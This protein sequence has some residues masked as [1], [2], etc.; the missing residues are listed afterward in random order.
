MN[1]DAVTNQSDFCI[2]N[3]FAVSNIRTTDDPNI[4]HL[5]CFSD[6]NF[7]KNHFF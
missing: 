6:F 7:T 2:S 1:H 4:W 3:N 5:E